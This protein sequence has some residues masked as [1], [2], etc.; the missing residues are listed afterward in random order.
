MN[1]IGGQLRQLASAKQ[2]SA[3]PGLAGVMMFRVV[4]EVMMFA[5]VL[6]A[7]ATTA[8]VVR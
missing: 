6:V 3:Q 7:I 8:T 1:P 5:D 2:K 4:K